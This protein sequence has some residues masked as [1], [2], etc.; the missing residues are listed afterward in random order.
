MP[1][2]LPASVSRKSL[3]LDAACALVSGFDRKIGE[4][5]FEGVD[6]LPL[7]MKFI[8]TTE[9][10]SVQVHP[11]D[12]YAPLASELARE[13]GDVAHPAKPSPG[14]QIAT[15]FRERLLPSVCAKLP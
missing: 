11:N 10:L 1:V 14:A 2:R 5:W 4:V 12:D 3:G 9:K 8:F 7:L 13:D 15:G 6:D